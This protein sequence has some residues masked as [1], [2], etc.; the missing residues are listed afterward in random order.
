[1]KITKHAN[2]NRGGAPQISLFRMCFS[3][4][5][6]DGAQN[7]INHL[8]KEFKKF[9][10]LLWRITQYPIWRTKIK[11]IDTSS[12]KKKS[13]Q[14]ITISKNKQSAITA[15]SSISHLN[16][17]VSSQSNNVG[18]APD[19]IPCFPTSSDTSVHHF[20][21]TSNRSSPSHLTKDT[22]SNIS[23]RISFEQL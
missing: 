13:G 20:D 22:L 19:I 5:F 23:Q 2:H 12:R 14:G 9:R 1:M 4:T 15:G 8:A 18:A 3:G 11:L 7:V 17:T 16:Q 10:P 6:S 21:I